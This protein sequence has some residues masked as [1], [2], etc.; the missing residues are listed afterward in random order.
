MR[1]IIRRDVATP[2]T[3]RRSGSSIVLFVTVGIVGLES[4][5]SGTVKPAFSRV[6]LNWPYYSTSR[7]ILS[8]KVPSEGTVTE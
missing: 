6:A 7:F 1:L 2:V 8:M 5:L 4:V 3:P